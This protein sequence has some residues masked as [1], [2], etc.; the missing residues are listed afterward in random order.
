M[1]TYNIN[2]SEFLKTDI[3]NNF[4][5]ENRGIGH[6]SVRA[7]AASEAVPMEG[8]KIIVSTIF[9]GNRIIIYDGYTDDSGVIDNILLPAPIYDENNLV[10]PKKIVYDIYASYPKNDFFRDY[11]INVFDG[12]SVLQN[13]IIEMSM[14]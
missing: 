13:I 14:E 10:S 4:I 12:I 11:S 2:D 1:I 5:N 7:Y 3:Y 9:S 8:V 6:L